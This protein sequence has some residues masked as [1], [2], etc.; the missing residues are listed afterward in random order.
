MWALR[1]GNVNIAGRVGRRSSHLQLMSLV[2]FTKWPIWSLDTE[3]AFT[4][5]G[6]FDREVYLRAPAEW[7]SKDGRGFWRQRAPTYGRNDTTVA[8]DRPLQV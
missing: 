4:Q 2:A 1:R 7:H 6:G 8:F 3:N 5:A